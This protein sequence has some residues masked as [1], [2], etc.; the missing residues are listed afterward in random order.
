MYAENRWLGKGGSIKIDFQPYPCYNDKSNKNRKEQ[1]IM[2]SSMTDIIFDY[3]T[4][5]IQFGYYGYGDSL[6]SISYI[7]RHF[8]VS[9]L[10]VR[11]AFSR[12]EDEGYIK[13]AERRAA[14]VIYRQVGQLE[15]RYAATFLTR[16][17]GMDDI[18]RCSGIIFDPIAA[19]AFRRQNPAVI[20]QILLQL[21]KAE[22]HE[23]KQVAGFMRRRYSSS[24]TR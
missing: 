10:T 5:R 16:K 12:L 23:A 13:T 15:R 22:G 7:R 2:E 19:T 3:F 21:K 17:D 8:Q 9:A 1:A 24:K 14:T 20:R 4:S 11:T 6:P 18:C